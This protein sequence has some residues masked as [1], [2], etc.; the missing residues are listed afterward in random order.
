MRHINILLAAT[1][2]VIALNNIEY[3]FDAYSSNNMYDGSS[4][5]DKKSS[6]VINLNP[7]FRLLTQYMVRK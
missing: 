5:C 6:C 3:S 4:Y 1:Y 7:V 2:Q